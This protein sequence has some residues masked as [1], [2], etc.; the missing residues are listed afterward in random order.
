M[1]HTTRRTVPKLASY[2]L[3]FIFIGVVLGILWL[4][5]A[6]HKSLPDT[7][8]IVIYGDPIKIVYPRK[9]S[10]EG[11]VVLFPKDVVISSVGGYGA[12]EID[13]LWKLAHD[14]HNPEIFTRSLAETLGAPISGYI[15]AI[16]ERTLPGELGYW[17]GLQMYFTKK[18][19]TSLPLSD[20]LSLLQMDIGNGERDV[21][22]DL[23]K[24]AISQKTLSPDERMEKIVDTGLVDYTLG[25]WMFHEAI[26]KEGM[27]VA[28]RNTTGAPLLGGRAARML[29]NAGVNVI[30]VGNDSTVRQSCEIVGKKEY[31]EGPT[32]KLGKQIFGCALVEGQV[33][34]VPADLVMYLG[35]SYAEKIIGSLQK[36]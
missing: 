7:E 32:A 25:S 16:G 15:G 12:Y 4:Y 6:S 11:R 34:D 23:T 17:T 1:R 9:P 30:S 3:I 13:S 26:R 20:F 28:V 24:R 29:N 31:L 5:F 21:T 27:R 35:T 2:I 22:L 36:K 19:E 10:G 33:V 8:G 14:E 18:L